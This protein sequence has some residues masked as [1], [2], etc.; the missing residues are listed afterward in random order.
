MQKILVSACLMGQP[1]RYNGEHK[2]SASEVLRRWMADGRVIPVCPEVAGGLTVPRPPAEILGGAGGAA[3]LAR[4]ARVI[5]PAGNDLTAAF[6]SGAGHA[7]EQV[8]ANGIRIAVLKAGSPSCGNE[9]IYDGTFSAT[10]VPGQ[11]VTA[12]LLAGAGV[13]VFN[14]R[15]FDEASDWLENLET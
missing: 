8:R 5:D 9:F 11:G 1:V 15:Q 6:I 10:R 4:R 13:R 14:E 7:L 2:R 3:V 12:A